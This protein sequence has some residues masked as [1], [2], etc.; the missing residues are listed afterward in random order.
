MSLYDLLDDPNARNDAI[1]KQ[2]GVAIGVVTNNKDPDDLG[3]DLARK[4][5][6]IAGS[7]EQCLEQ[8]LMWKEEIKPDYIM[9][10]MRQPGG[11]PQPE[12]LAD[13]RMFGEKVIPNL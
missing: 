1:G 2:I 11:P 7:P 5:R 12:A 10:R 9:L 6:L 3:F 4:D 8:L 13:I